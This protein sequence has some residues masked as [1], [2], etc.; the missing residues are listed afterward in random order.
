MSNL[1]SGVINT[2]NEYVTLA[3]ISGVTFE[4]DKT[5]TLQIK[6]S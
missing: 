5:Y 6:G 3:S 1:W 4:D 2:N